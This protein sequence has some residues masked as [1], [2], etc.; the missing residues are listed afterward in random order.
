MFWAN[1]VST[2]EWITQDL[3][4]RI[5]ILDRNFPTL[6]RANDPFGAVGVANAN[7]PNHKARLEWVKK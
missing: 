4:D 1:N 3:I 7:F 5:Y 6:V 2:V